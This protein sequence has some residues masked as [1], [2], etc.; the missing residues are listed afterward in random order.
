MATQIIIDFWRGLFCLKQAFTC[1]S[2]G[3]EI[4]NVNCTEQFLA[5]KDIT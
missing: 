3:F 1:K 2:I 5:E 4:E